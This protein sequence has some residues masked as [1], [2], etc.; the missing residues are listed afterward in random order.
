[1]KLWTPKVVGVPNVGILGLPLGGTKGHLDVA[2]VERR[3][4]CYKGEGGGFPQ[5]QAVVNLV[6]SR[7]LVACPNI[8]NVQTM[9]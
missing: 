4:D 9:H 1:V 8:E 5:V 7:L 2:P 6:S 3:K